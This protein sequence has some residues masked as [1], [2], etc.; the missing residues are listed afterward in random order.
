MKYQN[1]ENQIWKGAL[2]CIEKKYA[3][4]AVYSAQCMSG[5]K[6]VA[7]VR[8]RHACRG[9]GNGTLIQEKAYRRHLG[10]SRISQTMV[11]S[12]HGFM[13]CLYCRICQPR[14]ISQDQ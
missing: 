13:A 1:S 12:V 11:I 10:R 4:Q 14:V 3:C 7:S 6:L 5:M 8:A 9:G 2:I